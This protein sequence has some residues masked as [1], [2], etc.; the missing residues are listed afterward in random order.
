MSIN[1]LT[2]KK[3]IFSGGE[4][5]KVVPVETY[6]RVVGY[7]RGVSFWN[8]GKRQEWKEREIITR[9]HLEQNG[10]SYSQGVGEAS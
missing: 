8:V 9:V 10:E 1:S 7:Y 4:T 2:N 3:I 5:M 6:A